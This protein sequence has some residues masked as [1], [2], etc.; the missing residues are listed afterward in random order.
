MPTLPPV[1]DW[2][3]ED[4]RAVVRDPLKDV[5]GK[6]GY[7]RREDYA[8]RRDHWR[9]GA[10]WPGS[11]ADGALREMVLKAIFPQFTPVDTLG[12]ALD[13]AED[14]LFTTEPAI[15]LV[16]REAIPKPAEDAPPA[17]QAAYAK[18][19]AEQEAEID[20]IL[21]QL[22]E[23]WDDVEL[24]GYAAQ[25]WRNGLWST[26]G[27]LRARIPQGLL[28]GEGDARTL[29]TGLAFTDAIGRIRISAPKPSQAA[30][31][32]DPDTLLRT[33]VIL[34]EDSEGKQRAELWIEQP[35]R[36]SV[37]VRILK[38]DAEEGA[39]SEEITVDVPFFSV[40]EIRAPLLLTDAVLAQQNRK[41]FYE[42]G[43]LRTVETASYP[44]RHV[45]NAKR[46]VIWL[47]TPPPGDQWLEQRIENNTTFYA[48][49]LPVQLGAGTTSIWEGLDTG[50]AEDPGYTTP[51]V[52]R[53]E[54][55]DP[56]GS[57]RAAQ[58]ARR[59]I[60]ESCKQGHLAGVA[61]A[62][63][64]G[65]A[66]QQAR[67]VYETWL[68][69]HKGHVERL[70]RGV[71]TDAIRLAEAMSTTPEGGG[72]L[73]R[74][75]I[76]VNLT[77]NAGPVLAE[78]LQAIRGLYSDGLWSRGTSMAAT[79]IE[80]VQ[81]EEDLIETQPGAQHKLRL[82]RAELTKAYVDAGAGLRAAAIAAG[83]TAEEADVL[84]TFDAAGVPER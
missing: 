45:S 79:G 3:I 70:I 7:D 30:L 28:Q 69:R 74:Y 75:R 41:N 31:Y 77:V 24:W 72:I 14:G 60:L 84:V 47:T 54:P 25:A 81:A 36:E 55:V 80:D 52:Q 32:T 58:Y 64:S 61:T 51:A 13:N 59:T 17:T 48:H 57:I 38:A 1:T 6:D 83:H 53:F 20:E 50:T 27:V 40:R 37:V 33:G 18:A 21:G 12:E 23:W 76:V 2:K 67:A 29:P 49:P 44:E 42:T 73:D 65:I 78:M 68:K 34:Y 8:V 15:H 35:D 82:Q 26:R 10:E 46:P 4:A 62:E 56:D 9:E 16:P 5:L 11:I 19:V 43:Q 71:L 66:Y 63:A 39:A 22:S